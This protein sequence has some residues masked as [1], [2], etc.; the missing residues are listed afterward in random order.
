MAAPKTETKPTDAAAPEAA[1]PT[2]KDEKKVLSLEDL[3]PLDG[4]LKVAF[5]TLNKSRLAY[6]AAL[7]G[8]DGVPV[9]YLRTMWFTMHNEYMGILKSRRGDV[10]KDKLSSLT[11]QLLKL[12]AQMGEEEYNAIVAQLTTA[13]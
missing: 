8:A 9:R 5:D 2:A 10:K 11:D 1:A 7:N 3:E 12:K 6:I 13:K 4:K